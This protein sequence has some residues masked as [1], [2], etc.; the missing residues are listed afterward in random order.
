MLLGPE[1][2]S[3]PHFALLCNF[4]GIGTLLVPPVGGGPGAFLGEAWRWEM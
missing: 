2:V 1:G 4:E 3:E